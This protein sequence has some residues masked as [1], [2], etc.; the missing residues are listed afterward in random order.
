MDDSSWIEKEFC[1]LDLGDK[2]LNRRALKVA[3]A[4]MNNPSESVSTACDNWPEAKAAYR[5]FDNDKLDE[6]YILSLHQQETIQR[7]NISDAKI[8]FSIQDTTIFNYTHHQKKTGLGKFHMGVGFDSSLHGCLAHNTLLFT[9]TGEPLGLLDQSI[10]I[11]QSDKKHH[12]LRPI[13]EKE[14]YRW[15]Q[16]LQ[17]THQLCSSKEVVTLCDRESDIYEFFVKAQALGSK[18][19]VRAARDRILSQSTRQ[20]SITL[21]PYLKQQP[22][23]AKH[24]LKLPARHNHPER[25][26][27]L[28]IRYAQISIKAP[29]RKPEAKLK[30]LLNLGLNA[31]WVCEP[32]PPEG[33]EGLEWML[34]TNCPVNNSDN[35]L[36]IAQWYKFRWKIECYHRILK[37]GC[38]VEDCRLETFERLRRY[39]TLKSIIAYRLFWLTLI[40]RAK[41]N[42]S[43]EQ[44]LTPLEWK[45]LYCRIYKTN[46]VPRKSL[47]VRDVI[48]MIA[49]LGGF[50]GRKSDGEPGMTT[51]WRGWNKLTELVQLASIMDRKTCG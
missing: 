13:S 41:P 37:S 25:I 8:F 43:C 5:L 3:N 32:H 28:E 44:V 18:V 47:T 21:W 36:Q 17:T 40:N 14:S 35:A 42:E 49:K 22:L 9:E 50:L 10:F 15:I 46:K 24:A 39:L 27:H 23:C 34:L 6:K 31:V 38:K 48:H 1:S 33:I 20:N 11:H 2:R 7:L 45:V 19:V 26:A 29:Q 4:F 16:S 12:K 30:Q 51:I